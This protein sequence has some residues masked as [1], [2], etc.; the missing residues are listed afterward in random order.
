MTTS[1]RARRPYREVRHARDPGPADTIN[2]HNISGTDAKEVAV[3]LGQADGS[4]DGQLDTERAFP[5][6]HR[7]WKRRSRQHIHL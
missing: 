3:D 7:G 1:V 2:V 5:A 6:P 4:G